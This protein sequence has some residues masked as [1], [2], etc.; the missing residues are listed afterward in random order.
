VRLWFVGPVRVIAKHC[1][2]MQ[3]EEGEEDYAPSAEEEGE[4]KRRRMLLVG[5]APCLHWGAWKGGGCLL[6]IGLKQP[7]WKWHCHQA[8][9]RW[10][11][12]PDCLDL[13]I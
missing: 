11:A 13:T 1:A 9:K 10:P 3:A 5:T 2:P 8:Q 6:D 7:S 4:G 12:K